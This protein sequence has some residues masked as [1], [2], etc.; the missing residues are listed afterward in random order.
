V[1]VL[2]L[3]RRSLRTVARLAG[4]GREQQA[5]RARAAK[6]SEARTPNSPSRPG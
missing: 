2:E 6:Q 3:P 4:S 5:V 1:N